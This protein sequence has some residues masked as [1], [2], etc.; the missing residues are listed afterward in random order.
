MPEEIENAMTVL[1]WENGTSMTTV[2]R[3]CLIEHSI[4]QWLFS[5]VYILVFCL[6]L[7][8]NGIALCAAYKQVQRKNELGVYLFNLFLADLLY[9]LT[10]PFWIDFTIH[11]NN[12]RAGPIMCQICSFLTYTNLYASAA[13]LC[14][15]SFDRYLGVVYPLQVTGARTVRAA[16]TI[17]CLVWA[18]QTAF[19]LALLIQPEVRNGSSY[20]KFCY[21]IYPIEPWKATLNYFRITFGF[22]LPLALLLAFYYSIY[23]SLRDNVATREHEKRKAKQLMLSI[24]VGFAVCFT[25]FHATLLARS[26]MEPE[27]CQFARS[28]FIPYRLSAALVCLNCIMDPI[29][30]CFVSATSRRDILLLALRREK[31]HR[32]KKP[33]TNN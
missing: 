26:I 8:T 17:S 7:P 1:D 10:L 23:N 21:D 12:W 14:C 4:D 22:M 11:H 30:Y 20:H 2:N 16:V 5:I 28:I 24:A 3:A 25:P 9:V 15:I 19:N 29:L 13:F 27:N 6:G 32:A 31:D 18:V 33:E